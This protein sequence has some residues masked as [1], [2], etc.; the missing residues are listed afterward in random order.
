[1]TV[2]KSLLL[3][4][5][6]M[7]L[8]IA[9]LLI[10][11]S[12][13][14]GDGAGDSAQGLTT[15]ELAVEA[16][17]L[18]SD[19]GLDLS[20]LPEAPAF[21][22]PQPP[23]SIDEASSVQIE[24]LAEVGYFDEQG[25]YVVDLLQQDFAYLAVRVQ[26]ET[27]QPILGATPLFEVKGSSLLLEPIEISPRSSTDEYG[28]VEFAVVGGDMGLDEVSIRIDDVET[29]MLVNVISLEAA[30]FPEP[31]VVEGGIPWQ[32]LMSARIRYEEAR[33]VVDFPEAI[34]SRA[35]ETVKLSG[36]MMPLEPEMKQ[37][38]FLLTSNPPSCFFHVPGGPA[39]A[40]EVFAADGIE[41]SWNPIVIEGRFEPQS[42]SDIGVVYRLREARIVE[43]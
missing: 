37:S 25:R 23:V 39:G 5:F 14:D 36:F 42:S 18:P 29:Q 26:T 20:L 32:D 41:V 16:P 28:V 1:M 40:V 4:A 15:E 22:Q 2:T 38:R 21:E 17:G 31:L 33:L 27:G 8:V 12:A 30:G 13:A 11:R 43:Q 3:T 34:S 19:S 6:G 9:V 10:G 7:A 24:V 35:G